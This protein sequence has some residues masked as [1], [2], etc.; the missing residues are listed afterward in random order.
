[1]SVYSYVSTGVSRTVIRM[2]PV[3]KKMV[4]GIGT[5]KDTKLQINNL[6]VKDEQCFGDLELP[7][8]QTTK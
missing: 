1:M 6:Y 5:N 8:E 4:C 7:L 2:W 3:Q